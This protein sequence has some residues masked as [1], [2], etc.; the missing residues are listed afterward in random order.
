MSLGFL[1][2]GLTQ[3]ITV[4]YELIG[5]ADAGA[6]AAT[7]TG[8]DADVTDTGNGR[9]TIQPADVDSVTAQAT[10]DII[11]IVDDSIREPAEQFRV[12]VTGYESTET[13]RSANRG[14]IP[15]V[16][17]AASDQPAARTLTVTGAATHAETDADSTVRYTVALGGG[18]TA[19]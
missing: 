13:I 6:I 16:T 2:A 14:N 7:L 8:P 18:D 1:V 9:L 15:V 12:R 10:F 19:F 11:N 5:P 3:P 17:I 4:T